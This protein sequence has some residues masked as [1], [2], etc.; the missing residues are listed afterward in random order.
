MALL[1]VEPAPEGSAVAAAAD[2][3]L[4]KI[5]QLHFDFLEYAGS[6]PSGIPYPRQN[7]HPQNCTCC[8]VVRMLNDFR[9]LSMTA[10]CMS[11]PIAIGGRRSEMAPQYPM[12]LQNLGAVLVR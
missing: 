9:K 2:A 6:R 11:V 4:G 10:S 7:T 12:N 5:S 1:T 3:C 8:N